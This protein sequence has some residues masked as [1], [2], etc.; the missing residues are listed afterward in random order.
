MRQEARDAAA[1]GQDSRKAELREAPDRFS[2]NI[3][4]GPHRARPSE[5]ASMG[6]CLTGEKCDKVTRRY[7]CCW[8]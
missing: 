1:S 6:G 5:R 4:F 8:R 2:A 7:F 3:D